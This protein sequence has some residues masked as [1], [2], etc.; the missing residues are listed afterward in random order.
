MK[1]ELNKTNKV[2]KKIIEENIAAENC[3]I[4]LLCGPGPFWWSSSASGCHC[5]CICATSVATAAAA[6]G[7]GNHSMDL[8]HFA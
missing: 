2:T 7:W 5:T 8:R 3:L 6:S 1:K 4:S